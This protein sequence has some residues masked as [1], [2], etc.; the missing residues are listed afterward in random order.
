MLNLYMSIVVR[1]STVTILLHYCM[2]GKTTCLRIHA[3]EPNAYYFTEV[4][5]NLVCLIINQFRA[6]SDWLIEMY[7]SSRWLTVGFYRVP[8]I[9]CINIFLTFVTSLM[10]QNKFS[11]CFIISQFLICTLTTL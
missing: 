1:K 11:P 5:C 7:N 3:K 6:R 9:Q 4:S 10:Y 2:F 8:L